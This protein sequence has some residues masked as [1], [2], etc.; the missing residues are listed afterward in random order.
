MRKKLNNEKGITLIAL[1]I[2]IIVMLILVGVTIR[3]SQNGNLFKH[4]ANAASKTK[5]AAEGENQLS[6]GNI[7]G[8]TIEEI[9][10]EQ[11]GTV[12]PAVTIIHFTIGD[13][14]YDAEEGMTLGEWCESDYNTGEF[15]ISGTSLRPQGGGWVQRWRS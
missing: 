7:G 12:S 5:I 4:A 11:T 2:T 9:V 13:V 6:S 3:I 1:V 10:A 8:K 14:P 15:Y